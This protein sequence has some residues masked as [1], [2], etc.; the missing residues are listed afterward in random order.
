M[1]DVPLALVGSD[2]SGDPSSTSNWF[3]V[4]PPKHVRE[5]WARKIKGLRRPIGSLA[6]PAIATTAVL[7][8]SN[9]IEAGDSLM[10]FGLTSLVVGYDTAIAVCRTTRASP[11]DTTA[12]EDRDTT[13]T[14]ARRTA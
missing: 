1:N 2:G 13:D 14:P 4:I 10:A 7:H 9:T 3:K 6:L 5:R 11:A 8:F 12:G